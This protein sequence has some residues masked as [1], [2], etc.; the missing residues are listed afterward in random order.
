ME[1]NICLTIEFLILDVFVWFLLKKFFALK[2]SAGSFCLAVAL[3][4]AAALCHLYAGL[5]AGLIVLIKLISVAFVVLLFVDSYNFGAIFKLFGSYLVAIF[6]CFG[7][8]RFLYLIF[9]SLGVSGANQP[10]VLVLF[11]AGFVLFY[12]LLFAL[13]KLLRQENQ[14]KK[15]SAEVSFFLDGKHIRLKGFIDTGNSV[16]DTRRSVP[17]VFVSMETLK[18]AMP[19]ASFAYVSNVLASHNEKCELV[20]GE[21]FFVPIV[22]VCGCKIVRNG[23]AE[24]VKFSLGVVEKSFYNDKRYDCLLHRDFV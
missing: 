13:K 20:G 10:Y 21:C 7:Y 22:S 3:T 6:A 5:S 1:T 23:G 17:V 2:A 19:L 4:I 12:V 16:Y 9:E 8:Y 11:A 18:K 24:S 14:L 15:F